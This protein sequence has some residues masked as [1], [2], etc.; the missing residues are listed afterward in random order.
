MQPIRLSHQ[1]LKRWLDDSI[2]QTVIKVLSLE[3]DELTQKLL[4][5]YRLQDEYFE[6]SIARD[7]GDLARLNNLLSKEVF[8]DMLEKHKVL[9]VKND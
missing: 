3:K 1:Q 2:T 9:E 7:M 5:E 6:R 4:S 8:I